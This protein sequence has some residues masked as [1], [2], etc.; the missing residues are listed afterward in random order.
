[1][2]APLIT[3]QAF[4]ALRERFQRSTGLNLG[5]DKKALVEARLRARVV[6]K[7]AGSFNAYCD[8][9]ERADDGSEHQIVVDLLT[10]N[11]TYFFREPRHFAVLAKE[12]KARFGRSSLRVWSAACSTGEEPYSIAMTLLDQCPVTM[13]EVHASDISARV[14]EQARLGVFS[15]QRLE[16]M[17]RGYLER[18]CLRGRDKYEGKLRI[19][20]EVRSRVQFFRHNLLED[21]QTPGRFEVIFLRNVLIYFEQARK[22]ELLQNVISAL[23]PGGLLFV[24]H[25]EPLNALPL[26]LERIADAVFVKA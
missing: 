2:S 23:A 9:L 22:L 20:E 17:P 8:F 10:T 24:G 3:N 26:P 7:G 19:S 4:D 1:V 18:F 5:P 11:E 21:R 16:H 25:A 13:W 12:A 6:L 14:V 15:L